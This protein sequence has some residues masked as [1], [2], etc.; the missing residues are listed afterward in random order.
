MEQLEYGQAAPEE[1][2]QPAW[3]TYARTGVKRDDDDDDDDDD[4]ARITPTENDFIKLFCFKCILL[5][6]VERSTAAKLE[7]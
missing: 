6:R 3:R 1:H 7:V 2:S 4:D 5:H